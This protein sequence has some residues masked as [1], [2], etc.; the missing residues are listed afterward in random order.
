MK[1]TLP[2]SLA[3][4]TAALIAACQ[5]GSGLTGGGGTLPPPECDPFV[6]GAAVRKGNALE[7][8]CLAPTSSDKAWGKPRNFWKNK[9][10]FQV[11]FLN[12]STK[13][14][15]RTMAVASA[16]WSKAADITFVK[17]E[18]EPSDFRVSYLGDGHWSYVGTDCRTIPASQPTMNLHLNECDSDDNFRR[19]VLHEFGHALGLEHE[20][21][22]PSTPIQWNRVPVIAYYSGPPNYWSEQQI[23]FN[24]L[25]KYSGLWEGTPPD[26]K[27]IMQYPVQKTWT[28]NGISVGWNRSLSADD[29][30]FIRQKY[31]A[32]R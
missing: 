2:L 25:S 18:S 27:S 32:P 14:H 29:V 9:H 20:H 12:G 31:G 24:V 6:P 21:Q 4:L 23:E 19:V 7:S 1:P 13:L 5:N 30:S 28:T 22:H 17:V 15:D 10:V 26:L 8:P 16:G 3:V 11:R